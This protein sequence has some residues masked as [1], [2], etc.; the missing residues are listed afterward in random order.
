MR[1]LL[2]LLS[3]LLATPAF[4]QPEQRPFS[5]AVRRTGPIS[6]DGRLD[7]PDWA[8]APILGDFVERVPDPGGTPPVRTEARVLLDDGAV[9]VAVTSYLAPGETP[10]ALELTRDS[11]RIW[12]DDAVT[13]K[14]DVRRD[15]RSTVGFAV[16]PA[17]AQIDFVALDNGRS[18]RREYDAV[19]EAGTHV[20]EDAWVAEFRI[21]SAAL[22]L[23]PG[24]EH[25]IFGFNV[26]RDHNAEQATYDWSHLPP[27]FGAASALHYGDLGGL[28]GLGGGRILIVNPYVLAAWPARPEWNMPLELRAGGEVRTR[29]GED[30]WG[31]LTFLT[32]FAEVDLDS[33]VV[34]LDRFPLFFPERR[35]FFLT[36]LDVFQ[37]GA[38][39]EAQLFFT[40]R[41]GLDASANPVPIY[42]GLKAYGREGIF[43]FG[44]LD[45]ATGATDAQPAANWGVARLRA[46]LGDASY[47]GA[48]VGSRTNLSSEQGLFPSEL[49]PSPHWSVGL[50]GLVRA[51]DGRLELN[52][53]GAFTHR[54]GEDAAE[55]LAGR[56]E[57]RWRGEQ[58]MPSLSALYLQ[59]GFEPEL[60]FLR[61]PAIAQGNAS[62]P[63]VLRQPASGIRTL[64]VGVSGRVEASDT[65]DELLRLS[66]G[67]SIV[68]ETD[69]R[70]SFEADA[71]YVQDVVR[72]P[73]TLVNDVAI[74]AGEY[75]GVRAHI[76]FDTPDS[77][78]PV[79]GLD[80]TAQNA[81]FGGSLYRAD[82]SVSAAFGA[83]FRAEVGASGALLDFR[84]HDLIPTLALN[85]LLSVTPSP[86]LVIDAVG[87][88]NTVQDRF[89]GMLRL[90]WR[91]LPGSD[92]FLVWREVVDYEGVVTTEEQVT[93]KISYRYDAVL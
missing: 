22:R 88:L 31:E 59:E 37:F 4:A 90:R 49:D 67:W 64:T 74:E 11:F 86:Q 18:F 39:E 16:N 54:E 89:I 52:G 84:E 91:Y 12:S 70:L 55:G 1:R 21:P 43:S 17:G 58:W 69:E 76:G 78:N 23:P 81:F 46:N 14:F 29:L 32:D 28:A 27:E 93:L 2:P 60:G 92:L 63:L 33:Q 9:Y 51:L 87:Q 75:R 35:P 61:R 34:N 62:S 77:R 6:L 72:E 53:F 82:A 85:S 42:G 36:G 45:V 80:V 7:E 65:L 48:L 19:W 10:R 8:R 15:R 83:H 73:F 44:V 71:D 68:L 3:L 5:Q 50:D 47:V 26:T 41:I 25:R 13:L 30:I 57:V 40:R 56:A 66:G 79:L 20:R 24:D 38:L